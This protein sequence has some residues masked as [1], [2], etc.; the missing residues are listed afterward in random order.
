ML[1]HKAAILATVLAMVVSRPAGADS[2]IKTPTDENRDDTQSASEGDGATAYETVIVDP[3]APNPDPTADSAIV[4]GDKLRESAQPSTLDSLAQE[5]ADIHVTSKGTGI[6]GISNGASGGIYIRGL[7][8]SPNSQVLVIEDGVP[9]IQGIFGHPIP[10]AYAPT[11]LEGIRVIKGGDSVLYGSNAMGG[12]ILIDSRWRSRDGWEVV[13]DLG[14]GSFSTLRESANVLAR[15]GK[16][17]LAMG[18]SAL[19]TD[20]HRAGAGGSNFIG[21]VAGRWRPTPGFDITL[22]DRVAHLN[23]ADPGTVTHPLADHWYD[24]WR[25]T[26][27]LIARWRRKNVEVRIAPYLNVGVHRLYDGFA[28]TDYHGGAIVE[29]AVKMGEVA[30]LVGG[31][32]ATW[33]DGDVED[34]TTGERP[35]VDG[36]GD[37]SA[38]TQIM[39]SPIRRV[40]AVVGMR[41]LYD[42]TAG[43][44]ILYKGG[45]V[46]DVYKGIYV[47]SRLV[48]NFRH[49]TIRELYLPYPVANPDLSPE[50][51]LNIDATIGYKRRH[52]HV[53][54]TGFRNKVENLIK[55]FGSWPTAEVINIDQYVAWGVEGQITVKDLGPFSGHVSGSWQD[56]GRYSRQ[57]PSAKLVAGIDL[58]HEIGRHFVGG[59]L[60]TSWIHGLYMSN[61]QLDRID[62][63][64]NL[65]MSL[66]YRYSFDNP[67][68]KV[69][70]YL[71]LR[72]LLDRHNAYL[73]GYPMPGFNVLA[74]LTVGVG[75]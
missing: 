60:S 21:Q 2:V 56:V 13:N 48:R 69:E 14:A 31:I 35:E 71:L 9:D 43:P 5:S 74:G 40:K 63:V 39:V 70:P 41:F 57:N 11:L 33:T 51:S 18:V 23:G 66:R 6:H 37:A 7:G 46:V 49:P 22:R 25:N 58:G 15:I 65:D 67:D 42:T 34:R 1:G 54:V 75:R 64:V 62:D 32:A 52:L 38:Y 36:F 68:I 10:D 4:D 28:S 8:G 29:T 73:E 17:D 72:N 44:V 27:S 26:S 55:F 3:T 59:G 30:S 53:S 50:Y 45:L 61:Y 47:R 16:G 24:V 20:G 19:K 12:V